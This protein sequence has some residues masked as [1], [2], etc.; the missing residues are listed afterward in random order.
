[1]TSSDNLKE[2][3]DWKSLPAGFGDRVKILQVAETE[4]A[5]LVGRIGI[6]HGITTVS[7]SGVTVVGKLEGDTALNIFFEE[8]G[9]DVWLAPQLVEFVDHDPGATFTLAGVSKQ[10]TRAADGDWVESSRSLPL[11]EWPARLRNLIRKLLRKL[12]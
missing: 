7:I 8:T 12:G 2:P 4:A 9:K 6:V 1:M 5:G 11:A 3:E 10:W